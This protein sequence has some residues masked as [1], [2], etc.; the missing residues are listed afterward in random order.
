MDNVIKADELQSMDAHSLLWTYQELNPG[1]LLG[2]SVLIRVINDSYEPVYISF[3]GIAEYDYIPTHD[4]LELSPQFNAAPN[5]NNLRFRKGQIVYI[6]S[7]GS[8]K[9]SGYIYMTAYYLD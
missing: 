5:S 9:G 6:A 8:L 1:G 4:Y 7:A 3:D 2:P